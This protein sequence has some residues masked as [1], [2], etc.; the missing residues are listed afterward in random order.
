MRQTIEVLPQG[1]MQVG[2]HSL[3]QEDATVK[4]NP[5]PHRNRRQA[6]R[7]SYFKKYKAT[8]KLNQS[9]ARGNK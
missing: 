7:K 1:L 3:Q 8:R 2:T 6:K 9:Q 5:Q 4:A